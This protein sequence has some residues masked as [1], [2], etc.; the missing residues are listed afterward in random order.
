MAR[1]AAQSRLDYQL[2]A[3]PLENLIAQDNPVRIIDA[4]VDAL[5]L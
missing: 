4:F 3:D 2:F 5:P 1:K